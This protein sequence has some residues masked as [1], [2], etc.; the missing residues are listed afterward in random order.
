MTFA[1][2]DLLAVRN[3]LHG[4]TGLSL[5]SLGIVGD[6]AHRASGGYHEGRDDLAAVGRLGRDY[7][8]RQSRD[9]A[10]LTNAASA[11]DIGEFAVAING[12]TVTHRTLAAGI[13]AAM[14][15]GDPWAACV[16]QVIWSPD[17]VNVTQF[18]SIGEQHGGNASHRSHDHIS[19]WRDTEGRRGVFVDLLR[20]IINGDPGRE[21]G[22]GGDML[23][24]ETE[25]ALRVAFAAN[26]D[27]ARGGISPGSWMA[28]AVEAPLQTLLTRSAVNVDELA[29]KLRPM[30]PTAADV[31]R[32]IIAQLAAK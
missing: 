22:S 17:G 2:A 24:P 10:G 28:R 25:E 6:S 23:T 12:R 3:Y 16:R 31:A 11:L 9:K 18:D 32:E 19:F 7:S 15:R 30:L 21:P 1:P 8:V 20:E 13:V 14:K 29:A 4:V 26:Y 27:G 5:N